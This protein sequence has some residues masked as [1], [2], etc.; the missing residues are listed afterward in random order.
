MSARVAD[1]V[2]QMTLREKVAQLSGV[3]DV[4]PAVGDMAP[5]FSDAIGTNPPWEELIADGLGQLTRPFGTV[6]VEPAMGCARWPSV[7]GR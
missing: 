7:S 2:G 6:P 3:W 5:M 1:L 4:D